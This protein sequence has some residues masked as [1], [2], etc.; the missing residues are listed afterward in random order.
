MAVY[1]RKDSPFWWM[2]LEGTKV[3]K[4]T[5]VPIGTGYQRR[6]SRRAADEI[7]HAAQGDL[8]RG[9][10]RLPVSTP[11]ITF[12]AFA[13]WY[14]VTIAPQMRGKRRVESIVRHL[15][16]HFGD[17][18]LAALDAARIE[19][20][21]AAR[22]LDVA[23]ATVNRELDVLKPMLRKAI[24]KYLDANPTDAVKRYRTPK[25]PPITLL[26]YADEDKLLNVATAEARALVLLGL[27]ALLRLGDVRTLKREH[28]RGGHLEI[29]DPK[30]GVPYTVP[31][32]SRLRLALDAVPKGSVYY[33][34]RRYA[35]R[36]APM[37]EGTAFDLFADLCA[38]AGV[39]RGRKAGGITF[40]SLRHTGA[41]RATRVTKLTAVMKMGGW[42][43][44][45]QL[46]R[47]DHPDDPDMIRGVEGIGSRPTHAESPPKQ[48]PPI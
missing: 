14:A 17:T 28:D 3:R 9:A 39:V 30:T 35:K 19:E 36:D 11:A 8:A 31:V 21:K 18:P 46:A 32:S 37:G 13:Q 16:S 38:L 29:V 27:D 41:S 1:A 45:R 7:Y 5:G 47:Y 34:G 22:A 6:E 20:W 44:L 23:K 25:F 10:Y 43:S 2:V 26:T 33:F 48:K 24:P 12:R 42:Q 4:S 40:H 15:Q